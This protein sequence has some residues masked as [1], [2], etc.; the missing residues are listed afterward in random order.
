MLAKAPL[1]SG[2]EPADQAAYR[3]AISRLASGVAI[4]AAGQG[5][6]IAASTVTSLSSLSIEPPA[7]MLALMRNS[8][9]LAVIRRDKVFGIDI[10]AAD[11]QAVADAMAG[12]LGEKSFGADWRPGTPDAPPRLGHSLAHLSC[13]LAEVHEWTT[14]AILVAHVTAATHTESQPLL[15]WNRRYL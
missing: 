13:V 9:T 7:I 8:H 5:Q 6:D 3:D 14:H 2:Y 4:V 10:L 1:P 11:Q 15:H 12:R